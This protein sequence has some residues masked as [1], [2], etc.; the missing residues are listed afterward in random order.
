V[1]KRKNHNLYRLCPM[2]VVV[3]TATTIIRRRRKSRRIA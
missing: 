2:S 3:T 1:Q